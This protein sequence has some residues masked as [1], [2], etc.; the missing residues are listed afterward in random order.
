M[1]LFT[2]EHVLVPMDFSDMAKQ[3]LAET[4]EFVG[5]PQKIHV[6]HVLSN[7]EATE[8]GVI[9]GTVNNENRIDHIHTLF[10]ETFPDDAYRQMKFGVKV[11]DPSAEIIDY[12]E[13]NEI[14]LIIV[15]SHGRS[16]IAKFFMGSVA[17]RV[18]RFAHCAVLVLRD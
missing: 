6:L 9:W 2:K 11:G 4:L 7:L 8:P 12:A 18:V 17:E 1:T 5:D 13:H 10:N 3:A 14:D 15:A 16:G